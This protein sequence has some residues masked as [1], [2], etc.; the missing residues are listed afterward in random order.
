MVLCDAWDNSRLHLHA[1]DV[2]ASTVRDTD[3]QSI[4][5]N[6]APVWVSGYNNAA[7]G[8]KSRW[9]TNSGETPALKVQYSTVKGGSGTDSSCGDDKGG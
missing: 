9:A 7:D 3:L 2:P 5:S 6:G 8:S 4:P 1:R